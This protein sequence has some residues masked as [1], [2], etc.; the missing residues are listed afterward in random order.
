MEK[1][2]VSRISH[3]FRPKEAMISASFKL[4]IIGAAN[5]PL[6]FNE[7]NSYRNST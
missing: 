4:L 1:I 6:P 2:E 7:M 3:Y 5:L